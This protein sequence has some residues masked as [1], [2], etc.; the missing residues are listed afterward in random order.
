ALSNKGRGSAPSLSGWYR[1]TRNSRFSI[2]NRWRMIVLLQLELD[3]VDRRR[4]D[5]LDGSRYAGV[6]P[7][8]FAVA[9]S[10]GA[11]GR[12][13]HVF[14]DLAAIDHDPH[15]GRALRDRSD[16]LARLELQAPR[17]NAIV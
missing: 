17:T 16:R 7:E 15:A 13:R 8:E 4:P 11:V 14:S 5:V 9:Q 2:S 10:P 6:L 12:P 1:I 3:D